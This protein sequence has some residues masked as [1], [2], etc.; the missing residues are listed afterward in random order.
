MIMIVDD[1]PDNRYIIA[2]MLQIAGHEVVSAVNGRDA[3]KMLKHL[4]PDLVLLDLAMPEMDGWTLAMM[5]RQMPAFQRVP[6]IAVTGHVT[7]DDIQ[8]ALD[9]GCRDYLAKPVEYEVL[10]AKV[11]E[12]LA[13]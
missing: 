8:R 12:H 2:R 10:V 13:A 9:V 3:L 4:V 5:L 6:L 7:R 1:S 11:R